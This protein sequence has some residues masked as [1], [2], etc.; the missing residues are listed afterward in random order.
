VGGHCGRERCHG[1][2]LPDY[3]A[4]SEIMTRAARR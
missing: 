1:Y 3:R 4:T 2:V